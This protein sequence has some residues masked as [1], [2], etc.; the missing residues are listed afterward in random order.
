M[1]RCE[2]LN[3]NFVTTVSNKCVLTN[4][5]SQ[6][7]MHAQEVYKSGVIVKESVGGKMLLNTQFYASHHTT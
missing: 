6:H 5:T 1:Y 7:H 3:I 2:Q 4:Q